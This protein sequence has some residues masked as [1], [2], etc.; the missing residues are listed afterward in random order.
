MAQCLFLL[1]S[2]SLSRQQMVLRLE[3]QCEALEE[4]R[5]QLRARLLAMREEG[6]A[7]STGANAGTARGGD[8]SQAAWGL[9]GAGKV[10]A[11]SAAS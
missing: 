6:A 8:N 2:P 11:G 3:D 9:N 4:E 7:A 10:G 5:A 1:L